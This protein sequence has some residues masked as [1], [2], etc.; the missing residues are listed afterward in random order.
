MMQGFLLSSEARTVRRPVP[1]KSKNV[2]ISLQRIMV[3][4]RKSQSTALSSSQQQFGTSGGGL[5]S[6][7]Y[8]FA[9]I[10]GSLLI[11]SLL[12]LK[13]VRRQNMVGSAFLLGLTGTIATQWWFKH[14]D[15]ERAEGEINLGVVTF[16]LVGGAATFAAISSLVFVGLERAFENERLSLESEPPNE[17]E[18]TVFN[19]EAEPVTVKVTGEGQPP[20]E[21]PQNPNYT[22]R[23]LN[24][25]LEGKGFCEAASEQSTAKVKNDLLEGFGL[26]CDRDLNGLN[27]DVFKIN[28]KRDENLIGSQKV[29]AFR[30]GT[31]CPTDNRET[32]WLSKADFEELELSAEENTVKVNVSHA[33]T[34]TNPPDSFYCNLG[35]S[36]T[37][38]NETEVIVDE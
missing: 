17:T 7:D 27:V 36:Q 22:K 32:I 31:F 38:C 23:V 19:T 20:Y 2:K 30:D 28:P 21:I 15:N 18:L 4:P 24:S 26:I 14:E 10:I 25:C 9:V 29:L 34:D 16:R 5:T 37:Y 11:I 13:N 8:F 35:E 1:Y 33:R 6:R 12:S 3:N